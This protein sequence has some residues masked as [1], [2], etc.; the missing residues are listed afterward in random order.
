MLDADDDGQPV[1]AGTSRV[2]EREW[3]RVTARDIACV[4]MATATPTET[5]DVA[6]ARMCA[7]HSESIAVTTSN[8]VIGFV[9]LRD[10]T[11]VEVLLDRL[12]NEPS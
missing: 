12:N 6:A 1:A 5:V 2:P 10:L 4:D 9:T 7:A 8:T 11:N 3:S